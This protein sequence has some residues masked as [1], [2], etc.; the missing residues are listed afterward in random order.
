MLV[1]KNHFNLHHKMY[2]YRCYVKYYNINCI[3]IIYHLK[4]NIYNHEKIKFLLF[5]C[6]FGFIYTLFTI[7]IY[8]LNSK[9]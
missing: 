3:Y 2:G 8:N 9:K 7:Q 4:K 5:K 6:L 1:I